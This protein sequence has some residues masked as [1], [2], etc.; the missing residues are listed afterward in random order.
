M[1]KV[2]KKTA[3]RCQYRSGVFIVNVEH[4]SYLILVFLFLT[5]N[6]DLMKAHYDLEL[7]SLSSRIPKK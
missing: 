1:F 6:T 7:L 4:V 5:L 2:N 3:E